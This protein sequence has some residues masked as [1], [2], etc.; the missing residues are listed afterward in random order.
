MKKIINKS[1]DLG[2]A[3]EIHKSRKLKIK[4]IKPHTNFVEEIYQQKKTERLFD[5]IFYTIGAILILLATTLIIV[6]II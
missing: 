4:T 1:I 3:I 2:Q 6:N 5:I